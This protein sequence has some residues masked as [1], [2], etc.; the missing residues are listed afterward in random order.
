[1]SNFVGRPPFS[2][3]LWVAIETMQYH[4][5]QT[6]IFLRTPSFPIQRVPMNNLAPMKNCP[7]GCKVTLIGCRGITFKGVFT[8]YVS[9]GHLGHVTITIEQISLPQH[10]GF[11]I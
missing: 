6:K 2:N 5:A 8:I 1:M 7:G 11:I 4:I 10:L 3:L 9:G